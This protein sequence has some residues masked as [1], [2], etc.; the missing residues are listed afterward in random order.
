MGSKAMQAMQRFG[1]AIFTPVLFFVYSGIIIALSILFTNTAIMGSI[2]EPHTFW[3]KFW[4]I[5][6]NGGW[7]IFNQME[8]IFVAAIPIGL[9]KKAKARA[10]IEA[11]LIYLTFNYF[12]NS[13]LTFW[14]PAFGV[15]FDA[16]V[17]AGT[18]LDMIA[19]IKTLDTNILGAIFIAAISVWIHNRFFDK[20]LPDWLGTFQGSPLV[21]LVGFAIMLP[22]AVITCYVWPVV[23]SGIAGLQEFMVSTGYVG[24]WVYNLLN[25]ILIPTGLHHF[26]W[27]PFLYGPAV[28]EEGIVKYYFENLNTFATSTESIKELFP[29]GAYLMYGMEKVFAPIGIAAA[30]YFTAKPEKRKQVLALLI[31]AALTAMV[32]GITEPFEFTFLF[33]APILFIVYSILSATMNTIMYA[34]GI[35]GHFTGGLIEWVSQTWLPLFSSHGS[36]FLLQIGIGFTF[37]VIYFIVFKWMIEKYNYA[38]PGR[39]P[40]EEEVKLYSKE[41][42]KK[43]KAGVVA[44]AT[45][46]KESNQYTE[47]AATYLEALG[48]VDNIESVTNCATRLRTT[49]KDVSAVAPDSV[50]KAAGA[51]G[52]ARNGNAI[53]VIVGLSVSQVREEFDR[54]RNQQIK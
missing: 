1:G 17:G 15:D 7:T 27:M 9:A 22:L 24:I 52:V 8:V 12:I 53:Q 46:D 49:V 43:K 13:I 35:S 44:A 5:I 23:Q 31:P 16:E 6:Q 47:A 54:L 39:E 28:L 4:M 18:G 25:R 51:H 41:D 10:A 50:F 2:A 45:L 32:A 19:G 26:I 40:E 48:G 11:L 34:V 20:K 38:T 30:F 33:I 14:G 37:T 42:Y 36:T 29:E 21:G 3:Y